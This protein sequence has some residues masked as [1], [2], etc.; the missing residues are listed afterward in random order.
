MIW[1]VKLCSSVDRYLVLEEPAPSILE[2]E[3][4]GSIRMAPV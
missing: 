4:A 3:A 1:D 2:V